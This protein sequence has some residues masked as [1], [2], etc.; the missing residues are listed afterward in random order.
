MHSTLTI[1]IARHVGERSDLGIV[2][3]AKKYGELVH[4]G[5]HLA[6]SEVIDFVSAVR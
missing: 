5:T 3:E 4:S 6:R 1:S 2:T